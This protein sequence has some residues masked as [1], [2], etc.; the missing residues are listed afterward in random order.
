[1]FCID[2]VSVVTRYSQLSRKRTPS[3][4]EKKCPLVEL[5]TDENYSHKRTPKTNRVDVHLR[6]SKLA[7]VNYV[8]LGSQEEQITRGQME[9]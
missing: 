3:G 5:S 1:M 7:G 2:N 4:I 9:I 6:K 8:L